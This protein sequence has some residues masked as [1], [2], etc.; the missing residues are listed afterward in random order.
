M[1]SSTR[2]SGVPVP[3]QPMRLNVAFEP[4]IVP[5]PGTHGL[6]RC[7]RGGQAR[8]WPR[9]SPRRTLR[10]SRRA[11]DRRPVHARARIGEV[12]LAE[13]PPA[14]QVGAMTRAFAP[15]V[16]RLRGTKMDQ[17]VEQVHAADR[18]VLAGSHWIWEVPSPPRTLLVGGRCG[19]GDRSVVGQPIAQ[20]VPVP[21]RRTP[22]QLSGMPPERSSSA[23]YL[24]AVSPVRPG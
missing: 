7:P 24:V 18:R 10:P 20:S 8:P 2:A 12:L 1:T 5:S 15:T 13:V 17:V 6:P 23:V 19:A 11:V 16:R 9:C 4:S 22:S 3:S 14:I 21:K